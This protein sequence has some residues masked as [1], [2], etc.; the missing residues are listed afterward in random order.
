MESAKV[1]RGPLLW[2][3]SQELHSKIQDQKDA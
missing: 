2:N 1:D 3:S